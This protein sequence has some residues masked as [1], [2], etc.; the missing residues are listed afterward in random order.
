MILFVNLL[1]VKYILFRGEYAVNSFISISLQ[2]NLNF[3]M[4]V[5][6]KKGIFLLYTKINLK[7]FES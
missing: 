2:Y 7:V 3:T 6:N 4:S 1:N 5:E